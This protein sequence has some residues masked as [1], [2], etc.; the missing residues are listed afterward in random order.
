MI[1][2]VFITI[3]LGLY[4]SVP[5]SLFYSPNAIILSQQVIDLSNHS[6][7]LLPIQF[8]IDIFFAGGRHAS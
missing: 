6:I 5:L 8:V 7:Q 2:M 4:S 3:L 1:M